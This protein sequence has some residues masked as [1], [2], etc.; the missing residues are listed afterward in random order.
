MPK[1]KLA[2]LAHRVGILFLSGRRERGELATA[3]VQAAKPLFFKFGSQGALRPLLVVI[4]RNKIIPS[5]M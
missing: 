1:A 4:A 3:N 5:V 2:P